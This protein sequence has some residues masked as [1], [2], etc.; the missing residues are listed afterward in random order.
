MYFILYHLIIFFKTLYKI[1]NNS[2]NIL[3]KTNFAPTDSLRRRKN[4]NNN[5]GNTVTV[6]TLNVVGSNNRNIEEGMPNIVMDDDA[7][8]L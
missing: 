1:I 3:R 2:R 5:D 4:N 6:P 8:D 7:I